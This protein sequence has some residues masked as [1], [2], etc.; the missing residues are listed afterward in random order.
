[1]PGLRLPRPN[2]A[3]P[4]GDRRFREHMEFDAVSI[5]DALGGPAELRAIFARRSM[6]VADSTSR[7][8]RAR[9]QIP[10]AFLPTLLD[11]LEHLGRDWREFVVALRPNE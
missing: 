5:L 6:P 2:R 11:E 8:W 3:S 1:M 9:A 4:S 7:S 10:A